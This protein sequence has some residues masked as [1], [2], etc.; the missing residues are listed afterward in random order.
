[1]NTKVFKIGDIPAIIYGESRDRLYLFI[2]GQGGC[3]EEAQLLA[4]LVCPLGCSVLG[5]DLP[6]HGERTGTS[7]ELLPWVV[8][9]E[10]RAVMEYARSRFEHISLFANSIGAWFSML[11]FADEPIDNCLFVSP[12]LDMNR[13][14]ERMMQ[15]A[16]VSPERLER[17]GEIATDFG[18]T[19]S[20]RYRLFALSNP[21]TRW[22]AKTSLLY[23][24]GDHLV[25]RE[26]ADAFCTKHGCELTVLE[27]GEHWFHTESQ[28]KFMEDWLK[29]RI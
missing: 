29:N 23:G 1:M 3:K 10:L 26:T 8:V 27:G 14:I 16:G 20:H 22:Q 25:E 15:W 6:Q 2:H 7:A 13:L 21:I 11:A 17:E 4:E 24:S 9:P 5:I 18:Q 12:V 28:L 19:L